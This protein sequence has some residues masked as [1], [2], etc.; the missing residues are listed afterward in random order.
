MSISGK[1]GNIGYYN[2]QQ[3]AFIGG[4]VG[5]CKLLKDN[6][7]L[8][9][10]CLQSESG[11]NYFHSL[12]KASSHANITVEDIR[13]IE[14]RLPENDG[15]YKKLERFFHDIDKLITLHQRKHFYRNR[16][17]DNGDVIMGDIKST[18]DW[19]QRK[20]KD[21]VTYRRGSF[22]QPYGKK[23][24]YGGD[25]SMPFVQV[26]DVADDMKLVEKT[27]NTIS[28]IAQPMSVYVPVNSVVVTLQGTIG[29]VALTQYGAFFDRT[30][31]FFDSYKQN[32][33]KLFWAIIIQN[34][35][36]SESKR[37]P[38][39]TIKTITKEALSD[40]D[41]LLPKNDEQIKLSRM[42]DCLN[43]L[44]TL[45]QRKLE[46]LKNVKSALLEKMFV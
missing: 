39:G 32:T 12:I 41:L 1:I 37:A 38:G 14:I 42:F 27:K 25:D 29:R 10:Y 43:K 34:K 15:E 19:E 31:L 18:N 46:K 33:D 16:R 17:L 7:A 13:K 26:A 40:F 36:E 21:C 6:G 22:P 20:L 5:I 23:E 24:W 4:A 11:Q 30:V 9:V 45:H 35:F 44:I 3:K 2:L 28:K 8:I